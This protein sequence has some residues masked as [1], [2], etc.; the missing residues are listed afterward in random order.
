MDLYEALVEIARNTHGK[1]QIDLC[2]KTIKVDGHTILKDGKLT[3]DKIIVGGDTYQINGLIYLPLDINQLYKQ[4]KYSLPSERDNHRHYFKALSANELT[5]A[6]MV[7]GMPRFEARVALE[8]YILLASINGM[9]TWPNE[10]HWY[11]QGEDKDFII[12]K[13]YI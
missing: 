1:I 5:D 7:V 6:Q 4:Y 13:K 3:Q 9:L 8:A 12:L 2:N 11:W 10:N